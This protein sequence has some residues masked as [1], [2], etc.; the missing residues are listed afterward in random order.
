MGRP[1]APGLA[2]QTVDLTLP[3]EVYADRIN[4]VDMRVAKVFR[5]HGY[6]SRHRLRL[7]QPVQREYRHRVQP[8]LRRGLERSELAGG[9]RRAQSALCAVQFHDQLLIP[10]KGT[11][12]TTDIKE[13]AK[14]TIRG[15]LRRKGANEKEHEDH[16]GARP[17]GTIGGSCSFAGAL[18]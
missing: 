3:G 17:R 16:E 2:F 13:P 15:R 11:K 12:T 10:T 1:L 6:R 8:G 9:E 4:S 18:K 5:F 14:N 7:L